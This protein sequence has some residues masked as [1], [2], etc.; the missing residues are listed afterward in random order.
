MKQQKTN[1]HKR[2]QKNTLKMKETIKQTNNNNKNT[3]VVSKDAHTKKK[4]EN[5]QEDGDS[6][7]AKTIPC[8]AHAGVRQQKQGPTTITKKNRQTS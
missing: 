7:V 5:T 1:E 4:Q 6:E 2:Q 3:K 8:T